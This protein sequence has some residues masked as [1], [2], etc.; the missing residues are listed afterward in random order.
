M[1]E[2]TV[3]HQKQHINMVTRIGYTQTERNKQRLERTLIKF[4]RSLLGLTRLHGKRNE[5]IRKTLKVG[6]IIKEI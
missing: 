4:H 2:Y 1:G 6:N 3:S 5:N